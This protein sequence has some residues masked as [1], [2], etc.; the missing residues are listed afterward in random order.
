M[1]ER[2]VGWFCDP[3]VAEVKG[4]ASTGA[5]AVAMGPYCVMPGWD[6]ATIGRNV[7]RESQWVTAMEQARR[8]GVRV[9][10]KPIIDCTSYTGDPIGE[11]IR[12]YISPSNMSSWIQSYWETCF[13]PYLALVDVVAIHTELSYISSAYPQH[14]IELIQEIRLGGFSGPITTSNDFN[15]LSS[16]YWT[17]LNWIGGD[18]YPGIRTDSMADAVADWTTVAQQAAVAH[19][20]TG[21]N[22]FFGELGANYG[23]AM[24]GSQT[25][26]VY[27]AFWEVFGPLDYWAGAIGWRWPQNGNS[28][29]S[30]MSQ[31]LVSGLSAWPSFTSP[32]AVQ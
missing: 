14:F 32:Q 5:N 27:Q 20:Q 29:P 25:S 13:R 24:T 3:G 9:V 2:Y 10:L 11:G 18:A 8:S 23:Q 30:A 7:G 12:S 17:A 26:L 1:A 21:C 31:G 22:V 15:P 19:A 28:P 16:P 4:I 6:Y